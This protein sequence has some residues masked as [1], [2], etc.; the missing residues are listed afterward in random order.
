LE[1][2]LEDRFKNIKRNLQRA[3]TQEKCKNKKEVR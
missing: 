3:P 2:H 1:A